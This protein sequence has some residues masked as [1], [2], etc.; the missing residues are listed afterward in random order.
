MLSVPESLSMIADTTDQSASTLA[1]FKL[2]IHATC[3]QL[4]AKHR[5]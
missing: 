5:L 2:R 1:I 4:A 3:S